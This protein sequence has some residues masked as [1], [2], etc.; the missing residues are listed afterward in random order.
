M[1]I[2]WKSGITIPMDP[3]AVT[4][5]E[6]DFTSWLNGGAINTVTAT[7][8]GC[9][10]DQPEVVENVATFRVHSLVSS[11]GRVTLRVLAEDGQQEDFS[12]RFALRN[13]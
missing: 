5:Y 8:L 11:Q 1:L 4:D 10:V 2:K 9:S 7:A 3:Q 13:Q 12:V 6:I